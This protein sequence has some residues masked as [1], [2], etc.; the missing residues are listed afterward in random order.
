MVRTEN[1][2]QQAGPDNRHESIAYFYNSHFMKT[3]ATLT[4]ALL[5][6]LPLLTNAQAT[7]V[8][9]V[10]DDANPGTRTA[11]C[12]TF[13]GAI[14]K[15]AANGVINVL[16]P[17]GFGSLTI[18]KSITIDGDQA[19][20]SVL[21]AGTSGINI[22]VGSTGIV[23]L[24]NINFE[25]LSASKSTPGITG[26]QIISAA[27][28]HI[29]NC[30]INGFGQNGINDVN[31]ITNSTIIIKDVTIHGCSSNGIALAPTVPG[32]ITIQNANI[33]DC[34]D[35][36]D[37][38]TNATAVVA[39]STVSG[40]NNVGVESLGLVELSSSVITDNAADGIQASKPGKIVSYRN[41][42]IA[43]NNPDGKASSLA[44][45]K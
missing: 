5:V 45:L 33:T 36:I 29:E 15:T 25:G 41:N 44:T 6:C 11:P 27:V 10:G 4:S 32:I 16:D 37:V 9:G 1:Q 24:R 40:N 12:K 13:A 2:P 30:R 31:S 23:T 22:A 20:G 21:V 34:G 42:L 7:W 19:E 43:G 39:H 17:G 28:V 26:I 38:G 35:G 8:S 3:P 14:S 18:T